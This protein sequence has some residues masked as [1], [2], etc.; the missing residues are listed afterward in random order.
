MSTLP[1]I[2]GFS[3]RSDIEPEEFAPFVF[4]GGCNLSCP[5]CIDHSFVLKPDEIDVDLIDTLVE[6]LEKKQPEWVTITGGEPTCTDRE[7]LIALFE[8]IREHGA[9]VNLLTNGIKY[10]TIKKVIHLVSH[11][12]LDLK[13]ASPLDYGTITDVVTVFDQVIRSKR[14]MQ[15]EARNREDF[16][17]EVTTT[18]YPPFIG[19]A[20]DVYDFKQVMWE[21][22][23]WVL[24]QFKADK[25]ML[26]QNCSYVVPYT[27]EDLEDIL[28]A[29][30]EFVDD[31]SLKN[32]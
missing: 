19:D 27:E 17:Y 29:A 11:A 22:E 6:Y 32:V 28:E 31:V 15:Q 26:N 12:C 30:R 8:L 20:G 24:Q 4:L 13:S 16:S 25:S 5:Y 10:V 1:R 21:E 18:L 9:K 7:Q 14:I 23:K 3:E 2:V